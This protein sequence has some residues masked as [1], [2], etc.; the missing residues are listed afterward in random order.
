MK[1]LIVEDELLIALYVK[2]LVIGFGHEV[3]AVATTAS[4]AV[5]NAARHS[6][7]I[8]L[9]DIRLA[10]GTSGVDAARQIYSRQGLRCIFMSGN[11]DEAT[12]R[13]VEPFEPVAFIG[14]P[15]L[16]ALLR[17]ALQAAGGLASR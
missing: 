11:L 2:S 15:V 3:C 1:V 14:K 17:R 6:P 12:R 4:G 9:M 10:Q 13:A 7:D 8:V 5:E 16:P